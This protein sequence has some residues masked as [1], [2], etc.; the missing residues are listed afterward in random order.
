MASR[1]SGTPVLERGTPDLR[2]ND[3]AR[4]VR[5]VLLD[6]GFE[7]FEVRLFIVVFVISAAASEFG[8]PNFRV[9]FRSLVIS[10]S[11][12]GSAPLSLIVP[13]DGLQS[14]IRAFQPD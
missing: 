1:T 8:T 13:I 3:L 7:F 9:R 6:L 5:T 14:L 12:V 11:A 10:S 4:Q 2:R